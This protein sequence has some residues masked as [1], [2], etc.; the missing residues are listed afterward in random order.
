M[1]KSLSNTVIYAF[2]KDRKGPVF[3]M[4][5]M[6]WCWEQDSDKRPTSAQVYAL[7]SSLEFARLADVLTFDKQLTINCAVTAGSRVNSGCGADGRPSVGNEVWLC[8]SELTDGIGS[9]KINV[10]KYNGGRFGHKE[11]G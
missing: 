1:L 10:V 5:L 4:D 9:S 8:R 2:T 7:A 6:A 11:V 3:A